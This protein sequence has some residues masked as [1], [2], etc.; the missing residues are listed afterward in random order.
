MKI[1]ER[2]N[3]VKKPSQVFDFQRMSQ[4]LVDLASTD[5]SRAGETTD[6][7]ASRAHMRT[8]MSEAERASSGLLSF[9]KTFMEQWISIFIIII[10]KRLYEQ[11][12][13]WEDNM[14][15][16]P[17]WN[18][19]LTVMIADFPKKNLFRRIADIIHLISKKKLISQMYN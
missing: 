5:E 4:C 14:S 10:A 13:L 18:W 2:F 1:S 16:K 8:G 15:V 11:S 12:L 3:F 6:R 17:Q 19:G 7:S 9:E